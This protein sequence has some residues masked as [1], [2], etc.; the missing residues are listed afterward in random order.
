MKPET[1]QMKSGFFSIALCAGLA[2]AVPTVGDAFSSRLGARV[3]PV[4]AAVFE[5]VPKSG[6]GQEIWCGAADYAQ[7]EL[8]APWQAR[9][10]VARGRGQSETTGR[11]TAV[12]FTL[13]PNAAG[14][15]PGPSSLSLNTFAV[16]DSMS[17]RQAYDLCQRM[18]PF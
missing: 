18:V 8:R 6:S 10:Y 9:V 3:N 17:V 4:N 2:V 5:V 14:V 15:T 13:D 12:Q 7:R 16:G 11:R 1:T